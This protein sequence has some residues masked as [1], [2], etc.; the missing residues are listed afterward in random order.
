MG[1][2]G[3]TYFV[4]YQPDIAAALAALRADVFAKKTF[5]TGHK[6]RAAKAKT[7][8]DAIRLTAEEGTHSIL[9]VDRVVE[10]PHGTDPLRSGTVA[11][12][13]LGR[14]THAEAEVRVLELFTLCPRN[15]GVWTTV[16]DERGEPSEL[17]F[18]GKS[19]D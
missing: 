18:A 15:T 5:Y 17:M 1:A 16:Y 13:D 19:G 2:S 7:I 4:P 12:A 6:K 11:P 10:T 3:W 14:V 8:A 9:D